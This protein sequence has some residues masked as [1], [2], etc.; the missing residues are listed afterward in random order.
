MESFLNYCAK[1]LVKK[2]LQSLRLGTLKITD[3]QETY[4]LGDGS[5]HQAHGP[6]I[7]ITDYRFYRLC[8]WHGDIGLGMAYEQNCWQTP[9]VK[10]VISWFILQQ[11]AVGFSSGSKRKLNR[12]P[13]M[14][15]LNRGYHFL[16]RNTLTGS[17]K[18]IEFHYDLSNEFFKTFLDRSMTYSCAIF[19]SPNQSLELAQEQKYRQ[20]CEDLELSPGDHILEIGC[21]WLGFASYAV[22]HYD[23]KVTALT[24]SQQQYQYGQ[25]LI[26]Q[27]QLENRIELCYRDYREHRGE[28][29]KIVSIEMMEA[30]GAEGVTTFVS[31]LNKFIKRNGIIALQMITCPDSRYDQFKWGV[32]W[33]QRY[34]FPGSLLLSVNDVLT[35]AQNQSDLQLFHLRDLGLHY[36]KTLSSWY[37]QFHHQLQV[38]KKMGMPDSFIRR[39]QYY[40]KYCEAAFATRNISVV[41]MT[42]VRPNNSTLVGTTCSE[43]QLLRK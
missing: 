22:R 40:L 4:Y 7:H 21:G 5:E 14:F 41:Q 23:V 9:D 3:Q 19:T 28:Y 31:Y 10:A 24:I 6:E 43:L 17:K 33:I 34:I 2:K 15:W 29:D 1:F 42:L 35:K 18:N 32:D 27:H 13:I 39:W 12:F 16:K 8:L 38:V 36:A 37:E 11:E 20:L 26:K 25:E 30:L